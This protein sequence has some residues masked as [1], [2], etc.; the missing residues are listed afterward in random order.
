MGSY[1]TE[2]TIVIMDID[3][4]LSDPEHR[5][6]FVTRDYPDWK[7]FMALA[8]DDPLNKDIYTLNQMC[9]MNG[10]E[11]HITTG[12][13]EDMRDI[14]E[15]WL[16]KYGVFYHY[17]HMRSKKDYRSDTVIKKEI[18]DQKFVDRDILFAVDDRQS[19]VD[20][21]RS[22]GIRTLQVAAGDF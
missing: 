8:G 18:Y 4:T 1:N 10:F 7:S 13:M 20:M 6:H 14:T 22:L 17:L 19:V 2:R 12:R 21:W 16:E 15:D 3:G 11:I 5:R 9:Y